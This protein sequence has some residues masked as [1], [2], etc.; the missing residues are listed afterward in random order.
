MKKDERREKK[1]SCNYCGRNFKKK[2]GCYNKVSTQVE[3]PFCK[4]ILKTWISKAERS[5]YTKDKK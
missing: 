2:V 3:C 5:L 4:N 1:Y